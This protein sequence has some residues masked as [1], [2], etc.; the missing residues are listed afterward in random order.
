[1]ASAS[2]PRGPNG[3]AR[4]LEARIAALE[5]ARAECRTRAERKP[6]NKQLHLC[7]DLLRW[8]KSRAGYEPTPH[9]VGLLEPGEG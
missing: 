2:E 3:M 1:M 4:D 7:R 9:D 6:V 5:A 8:V